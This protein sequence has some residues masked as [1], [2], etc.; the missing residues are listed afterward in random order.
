MSEF[1]QINDK[2]LWLFLCSSAEPRHFSDIVYGVNALTA[3]GVPPDNIAIFIDDPT[4]ELYLVPYGIDNIF[5]LSD[6][7]SILASREGYSNVVAIVGGHGSLDGIGG[8]GFTLPASPLIDSIRSIPEVS[9]GVIILT[10]C[11]GGVFNYVSANAKPELAFLG[12]T[13]LHPSLSLGISLKDPISSIIPSICLKDWSAN[14]FSYS[15]FEWLSSPN[16]VDGDGLVSLIDAFKYSGK[17]S[18][19]Y[20]RY[21]KIQLF[22]RS[23]DLSRDLYSAQ[24]GVRLG[25]PQQFQ[26]DAISRQ[27]QEALDLLHISQ[28]PWIL[29]ANLARRIVFW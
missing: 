23:Q 17:I 7:A 2:S 29:H 4:A 21:A 10:Q 6:I 5:Q 16:D 24:E 27:L 20:L 25:N 11:F 14:I 28:D 12:A 19:D 1:Y 8:P 13:N 9:F 22:Q 15:F 3:K 26:V 18:N